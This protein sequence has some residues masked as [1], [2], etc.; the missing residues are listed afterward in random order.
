M[1]LSASLAIGQ[2]E[3]GGDHRFAQGL[4]AYDETVAFGKLFCSE[5]WPE[6]E[7]SGPDRNQGGFD[8][9]RVDPIVRGPSSALGDQTS[10]TV[11]AIGSQQSLDLAD[12]KS[13]TFGGLCLGERSSFK[14]LDRL[15][16]ADLG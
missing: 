13:Q 16:T 6:V 8:Q 2:P 7:I 14:Q 12:V 11:L 10:R 3:A 15:Q 4:S 1:Q 5:R 9:N